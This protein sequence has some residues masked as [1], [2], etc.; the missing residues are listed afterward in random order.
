MKHNMQPHAWKFIKPGIIIAVCANMVSCAVPAGTSECASMTAQFFLLDPVTKEYEADKV[1]TGKYNYEDGQWSFE[2]VEEAERAWLTTKAESYLSRN[3]EGQYHVT[4]PHS[5]ISYKIVLK[6][7]EWQAA[8][9]SLYD[10][11][12]PS[13][14]QPAYGSS[15][16]TPS[17]P[18]G[19]YQYANPGFNG[20]S[21][22]SGSNFSSGGNASFG[23]IR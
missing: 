15:Y 20:G 6:C 14:S 9:V 21:Y 10:Y 1:Q 17:V 2:D 11:S 13:R 3:E 5:N 4:S 19:A 18:S 8:E 16:N 12:P 23:G 22:S 7:T